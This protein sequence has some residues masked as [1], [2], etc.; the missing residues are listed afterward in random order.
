M[1]FI[2][3]RECII[4]AIVYKNISHD[5]CHHASMYRCSKSPQ[6]GGPP[7]SP[8]FFLGPS[9]AW[10]DLRARASPTHSLVLGLGH[11]LSPLDSLAHWKEAGP[12]KAQ[13]LPRLG[14]LSIFNLSIVLDERSI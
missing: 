5:V 3:F 8:H 1:L 11:H 2:L 6:P 13:C 4:Y 7:K 9:S 14:L 12:A 10:P